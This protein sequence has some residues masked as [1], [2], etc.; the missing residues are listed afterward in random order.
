MK[1]NNFL[2]GI[3]F[4][5]IACFILVL[6]F[7]VRS[8][9]TGRSTSATPTPTPRNEVPEVVSRADDFPVERRV[10]VPQSSNELNGH[11]EAKVDV[12][13]DRIKELGKRVNT[14]EST[15]ENEYDK[16]QKRLLL[17]LDILS[18]SE[19]RAEALRKL[20]FET[21]ERENQI[22]SRLDTLESELRPEMIERSV[23]FAGSL[24]PEEIRA[25]RRKS[26]ESE[27][28]NLQK[29]LEELSI[30]KNNLQTSVE[31]ADILV[32]KL[33][34]KLEKEIDEAISDTEDY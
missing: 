1:T 23:A 32:E 19:Q 11:V 29:F 21:M 2:H 31:K 20:L 24:R 25:Q 3:T 16:T 30:S 7:S 34:T 6:S 26:L 33:R 22:R 27:K 12:I 18:R 4:G 9:T 15:K 10:V 14:L 8:Q 5:L 17:N 28:A 13:G